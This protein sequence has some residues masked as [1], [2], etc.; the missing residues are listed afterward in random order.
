MLGF[1]RW[2]GS[3][4]FQSF[5][6]PFFLWSGFVGTSHSI[7]DPLLIIDCLDLVGIRQKCNVKFLIL[8]S[9]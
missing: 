3:Y 6:I 7:K 8:A 4:F 5:S 9:H 1:E 2:A